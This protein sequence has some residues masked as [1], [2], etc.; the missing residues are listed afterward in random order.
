M[1]KASGIA[2]FV[3]CIMVV[4]AVAPTFAQSWS[5][6]VTPVRGTVQS[7]SGDVLTVNSQS[8]PVKIH[9]GS[10]LK[11]Y[12]R[13]PSDLAH[14]TSTSFVGVTSIKQ[15]DGSERATEIHI[16]PEELRGTGEGSYLMNPDQG[17][18]ASGSRM[19]NGSVSRM[20]NGSVATNGG[21]PKSRMT[22]G[23]VS[24]KSGSSTL[25]IQYGGGVETISV[26]PNV[27]VTA[28]TPTTDKLNQGQRIFVLA[29][30]QSDGTFGSTTIISADSTK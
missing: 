9:L 17:K 30:K 4:A 26:P 14:V 23:V 6:G 18:P 29:K 7:I 16:F 27:T 19:T 22:N 12:A 8:G 28:L 25:S 20:T 13:T 10:P 1:R 2:S 21:A 3:G 24:A 11:V 5:A 15:P